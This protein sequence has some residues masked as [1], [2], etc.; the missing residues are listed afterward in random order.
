MGSRANRFNALA[1]IAAGSCTDFNSRLGRRPLMKTAL[2][3]I[4]LLNLSQ[5]PPE[6]R[7]QAIAIR[8][9]RPSVVFCKSDGS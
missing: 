5:C 1:P 6:L 8:T 4:C 2:P 3:V 9:V 7:L